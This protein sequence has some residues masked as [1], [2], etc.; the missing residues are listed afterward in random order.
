[1][2]LGCMAN[3][4]GLVQSLLWLN[5]TLIMDYVIFCLNSLKVGSLCA[6]KEALLIESSYGDMACDA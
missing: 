1:M 2:L 3:T 5:L 6:S 4:N